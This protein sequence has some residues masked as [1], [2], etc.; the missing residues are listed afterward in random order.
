MK[1]SVTK[2]IRNHK[3]KTHSPVICVAA[4][5]RKRQPAQSSIDV[6]GYLGLA[7]GAP[8]QR[9]NQEPTNVNKETDG[10]TRETE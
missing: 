4:R 9:L 8:V 3:R 10:K 5:D 6:L 7:E 1:V 2:D